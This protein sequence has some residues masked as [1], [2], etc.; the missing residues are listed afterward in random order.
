MA[1]GDEVRGDALSIAPRTSSTAR[2]GPRTVQAAKRVRTFH[3]NR[4]SSGVENGGGSERVGWER[5]GQGAA[6]DGCDYA[7]HINNCHYVFTTFDLS[8]LL[9]RDDRPTV[10]SCLAPV[11][12]GFFRCSAVR[13][14]SSSLLVVSNIFDPPWSTPIPQR[15]RSIGEAAAASQFRT[16]SNS[17]LV[18]SA[19]LGLLSIFSS[20]RDRIRWS[21][22]VRPT[23]D[24]PMRR[25]DLV[26]R[27]RCEACPRAGPSATWGTPA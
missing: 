19:S 5:K 21:S 18:R 10:L 12:R 15:V 3:G 22:R 11:S 16:Q 1:E 25:A 26:R 23:Q 9:V 2:A 20:S 8:R 14:G 27:L 13:M 6:C 24:V 4:V 7:R 17:I